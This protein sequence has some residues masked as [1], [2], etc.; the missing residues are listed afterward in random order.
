MFH[1]NLIILHNDKHTGVG[2]LVIGDWG[3]EGSAEQYATAN[4]LAKQAFHRQTDFVISTGDNFYENGVESTRD[5]LWQSSFEKV[6]TQPSLQIPWYSI[7]GNHDYRSNTS[8]QIL[9]SQQ[10]ARWCMPSR[11]YSKLMKVNASSDV[12][13]IF[14]DTTPLI[15]EYWETENHPDVLMQKPE[16]QLIWLEKTLAESTAQWKI[17][18]GHHPVF[19][20]SPMHGD[21]EELVTHFLP[22]FEEHGVDAYL[23]GHEHDLQLHKPEGNTMYLVSGAGSE[24]RETDR[25]DMTLFSASDQGFAYIYLD[26]EHMGI[27]FINSQGETI[28][29]TSHSH[30]TNTLSKA[31]K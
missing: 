25:K 29:D 14:T 8:A 26:H 7:L 23:C 10:S 21:T 1:S 9:Y 11:Y 27:A 28:F 19:S 22:L 5:S 15:G 6:Y 30:A 13:F 16:E 4:A 2:F 3:R 24:V 18:V 31:L 17:V 20:S 12:H